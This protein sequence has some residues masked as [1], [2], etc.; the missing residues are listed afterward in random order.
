MVSIRFL[1]KV[2]GWLVFLTVLIVSY[3]YVQTEYD[4]ENQYSLLR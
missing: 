3:A 2:A 4:D 1:L